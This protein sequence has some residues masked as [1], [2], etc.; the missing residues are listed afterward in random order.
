MKNVS[1]ILFICVCLTIPVLSQ[2][3][4]KSLSEAAN[5]LQTGNFAE[6]E[7]ILSQ[8]AKLAP[9]NPD[10]H[11]LLGIIYDQKGDFKQAETKYR[12]AIRLNPKAVSPLANLGV[13][14]AKTKRE[15]EAINT[16][17]SVLKINPNHPPTIINLGFLYN[18]TGDFPQAVEFLS[19]ANQIQPNSRDIL[20]GLGNALFYTKKFAEAEQ[21]FRQFETPNA[22]FMRGEI[23]T[24]QKR[25]P[26]AVQFY[27][28]AVAADK[29]KDVY[30]VRLGGLYLLQSKFNQALPYFQ[31]AAELFP[32]IA[33]IKYFL[34]IT[35]RG[36]GNYDSAIDEV[37]KSLAIKETADSN[38]LL[39]AI[40]FDRN[41]SPD[42]EKYLRKAILL[43][44]NHINSH[45]DLGRLLVKNQRYRESL[46]IL[47]KAAKLSP[48]NPEIYYQ[49]FLS[50]SRLK[51]KTEADTALQKFKQ[52][53]R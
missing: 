39:G 13:L 11:N 19:K 3:V 37:K 27:E 43:N 26:E 42:A 32:N 23:L 52:L 48:A 2:D 12:T 18:S 10:V 40:L 5:Y 53:S 31:E 25:Y 7:K 15:K 8:A 46:P 20:F 36:L 49:L 21:I 35:F 16:F 50:Y 9:S 1:F 14:L 4:K 47:E 33:E 41:E 28:K 17:E 30:F 29:T 44:P 51:R 34:A 22:Y 45:Y 24:E 38:A 6:A